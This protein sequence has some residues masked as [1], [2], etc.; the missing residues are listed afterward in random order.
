LQKVQQL[1]TVKGGLMDEFKHQKFAEI[2]AQALRTFPFIFDLWV[3]S[4]NL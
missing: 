3:K 4:A 1:A 2:Q